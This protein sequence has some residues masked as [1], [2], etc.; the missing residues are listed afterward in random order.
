MHAA[1]KEE[2]LIEQ[3]EISPPPLRRQKRRFRTHSSSVIRPL[4]AKELING[5]L[6]SAPPPLA[7]VRLSLAEQNAVEEYSHPENL[8]TTGESFGQENSVVFKAR[9]FTRNPAQRSYENLKTWGDKLRIT[10]QA[11]KP[12]VM[13]FIRINFR[14]AKMKYARLSPRKQQCLAV[15]PYA[16]AAFTIAFTYTMYGGSKSSSEPQ[17]LPPLKLDNIVLTADIAKPAP[18]TPI[19]D[20]TAEAANS[21]TEIISVDAADAPYF[22]YTSRRTWLRSQMQMRSRKVIRLK[23]NTSL[24]IHPN[25]PSKAGWVLAQNKAG[26]V[27]FVKTRYLSDTKKKF[28]RRQ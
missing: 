23:T 27:G 17:V 26:D 1:K 13:Q 10:I 8:S 16:I 22:Q 14:I 15:A 11:K 3:T 6:S 12:V 20:I 7:D 18:A 5:A 24:K 21:A 25:F 2:H 28:T 4:E 9:S 19:K